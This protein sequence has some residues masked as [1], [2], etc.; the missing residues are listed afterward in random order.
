MHHGL[1]RAGSLDG[2]SFLL[3]AVGVLGA[4]V[5]AAELEGLFKLMELSE[6]VMNALSS[7]F[8][9]PQTASQA[10]NQPVNLFHSSLS[11]HVPF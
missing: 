2:W 6:K 11:S 7:F 3:P 5:R 4:G 1:Q 9:S 8:F 10:L